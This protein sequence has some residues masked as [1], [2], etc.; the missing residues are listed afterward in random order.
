MFGMVLVTLNNMGAIMII[1]YRVLTLQFHV[2]HERI[3]VCFAM[4]LSSVPLHKAG[5]PITPGPGAYLRF[6][7]RDSERSS[8]FSFG[9]VGEDGQ[10]Y[11]RGGS[12]KKRVWGVSRDTI[13]NLL[14]CMPIWIFSARTRGWARGVWTRS[15]T[16][17]SSRS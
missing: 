4:Q 2:F 8:R 17:R 9:K 11:G 13:N 16:R 5:N 10:T 6:W 1:M 3:M 14:S 15:N 12:L 7:Q